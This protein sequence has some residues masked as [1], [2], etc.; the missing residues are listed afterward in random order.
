MSTFPINTQKE[1]ILKKTIMKLSSILSIVAVLTISSSCLC[2]EPDLKLG[3]LGPLTGNA[4]VLGAD[5]LPAIQI[6]IEEEK[7]L[8]VD[9][10]LSIEDDQ[11]VTSKSITS[12]KKLTGIDN[13]DAMILLTYGGL[14][15]LKETIAKDNMLV[16]DTLDC[17]EE[18]AKIETRN[19]I[20]LSKGTEDMGEVIAKTIIAR[21]LPKVSFIYFDGDPFMGI[22]ARSTKNYLETHGD[23][24]IVAYDGYSGTSDF[25]SMLLKARTAGSKG[26]IFYG[27]DELGNAYSQ[28]RN[29]GIKDEF[30]GVNTCSSPGFKETARGALEGSYISTYLAPRT[31]RYN[32]F[33]KTFKEKTG[34]SPSFEVSTFPSYDAIKIIGEGIRN[35]RTSD[36]SKSLKEYLQDYI[37]A[38]KNYDGLAGNITIDSDGATRSIKNSLYQIK[39]ENLEAVIDPPDYQ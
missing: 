10:E 31:E 25:K 28:A 21:K 39:G 13:V 38:V 3:F 14:F 19:V 32:A 23:V 26:Y 22:L 5:A 29:L 34:R 1:T 8:G 33:I 30:F 2:A 9:I 18:I 24:K 6:A 7:A 37:Y 35:Y 27:Y 16:I 17:D 15:A 11:Y 12:Y 4:A 36:K 20:C